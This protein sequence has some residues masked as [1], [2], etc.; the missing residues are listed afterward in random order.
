MI[1]EFGDFELD[2]GRFELR[3]SGRRVPMEP[4]VFEVLHHL[5]VNRDRL[6]TRVELLD[7]V[8]GD[9]FVSDSA[10]A[11]RIRDAR[12][13]IGDD[14][15]AQ[16][17]IRTVHGRG[18]QFI[19][20]TIEV[21]GPIAGP[22]APTGDDRQVV[23][24]CSAGDGHQLAVAVSGQGPPLVKVANWLTHVEQ[25][26]G[27]PIWNHWLRDLGA[28]FRLHRYDAR[29]CG[30]SDRDLSSSDLS[31]I[32]QWVSD[33]GAVIDASGLDTVALLGISQGAP[34]AVNYAARHP[35]R[36]SHLVLHG[37]YA[38]GM[39]RRGAAEATRAELLVDLITKG[40]GG[41]NP[42]FRGVFTTTFVPQATSEQ[43]R[44]F[45]D[46]QACTTSP[47]NAVLF[48]T[49]FHDYELPS[50]VAGAVRAPTL[51]THSLGDMATPFEEGRRLAGAIPGAELVGL[52]SDN[53]LLLDDEPGWRRFVDEVGRFV[54]Q[55]APC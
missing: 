29:G 45:N 11:S 33:L 6:V 27:S 25:D 3:G 53:H 55:P 7:T 18:Y 8:W 37:G 30:L 1:L 35:E 12:A 46:L 41:T 31:D 44:W 40:W 20:D 14:G 16:R 32:D 23:R 4:Q 49:A 38:R 21:A 15:S 22:S 13:A 5:V 42:A 51:V 47:E 26:W 39:R 9:R 48:E 19:A 28:R 2:A 50:E 43:M 52:D 10:L 34:V 24:F 36:V 54:A 17:L